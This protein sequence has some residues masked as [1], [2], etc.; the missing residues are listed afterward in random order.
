MK[1]GDRIHQLRKQ[2]K[3]TLG[4]LS[5]SSRVALATISRIESNKMT[6]TVEAHYR[7]ALALELTLSELYQDVTFYDEILSQMK[8]KALMK[9]D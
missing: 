5:E 8:T 6:G 1:L 4:E 3:L 7:I 9:K 2:K